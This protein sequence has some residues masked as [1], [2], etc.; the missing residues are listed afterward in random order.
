MLHARNREA[1]I[2]AQSG[3]EGIPQTRGP[4]LPARGACTERQ[5]V[6]FGARLRFLKG[7][8]WQVGSAASRVVIATKLRARKLQAQHCCNHRLTKLKT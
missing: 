4:L 8:E 5:V 3:H 7:S 6:N 2:S 1:R